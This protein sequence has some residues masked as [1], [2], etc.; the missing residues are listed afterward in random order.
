MQPCQCTMDSLWRP[1]WL[2]HPTTYSSYLS[3]LWEILTI[4]Q[5][6]VFA[7]VRSMSLY[8]ISHAVAAH[9]YNN[10]GFHLSTIKKHFQHWLSDSQ[11]QSHSMTALQRPIAASETSYKDRLSCSKAK[12]MMMLSEDELIVFCGVICRL[13]MPDH[14]LI[15]KQ[16]QPEV[17]WRGDYHPLEGRP[18]K[19]KHQTNHKIKITAFW[20][21]RSLVKL[22]RSLTSKHPL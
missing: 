17:G 3:L 13:Q 19:S 18:L 9:Y 6:Q 14:C 2:K 15:P 1:S 10:T 20:H 11:G 22:A 12:T 16:K 21:H 5:K 8:H 7:V 4:P